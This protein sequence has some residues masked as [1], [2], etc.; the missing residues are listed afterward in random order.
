MKKLKQ[1]WIADIIIRGAFFLFFMTVWSSG[2]AGIKYLCEQVYTGKPLELNAF[3]QVLLILVI[4]T[5]VFGRFFCGKACAFG[6]YGDAVYWISARIAKL[7]GKKPPGIPA[8]PEK[9]L[10][11]IKYF[12]LI[13]ICLMCILGMANLII[14]NSPWTAFANVKNGKVPLETT[15]DIVG[16]ALLIACTVGMA[17]EKRFFCKF[18]CPF[19]AVFALLPVFP[20]SAVRRKKESCLENC[21]ACSNICVSKL[22]IP[23]EDEKNDYSF[24]MGD[25]FQCGK[26]TQICPAQ[27]A[28]CT[29][30]PGGMKGI[31]FDFVKGAILALSLYLIMFA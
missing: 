9:K 25:C 16:I 26:C 30:M 12:V 3:V 27:N 11:Y 8:G 5:I 24:K 7:L 20:F 31:I 15:A 29:T 21:R 17:V 10:K 23:Y 14:A 1:Q 6:T 19:G 13:G 18:L 2:F 4:F 28:E 22:D